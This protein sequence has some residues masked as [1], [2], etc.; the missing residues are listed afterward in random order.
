MR[1]L[2]P[3]GPPVNFY[4]IYMKVPPENNNIIFI[5]TVISLSRTKIITWHMP[6]QRFYYSVDNQM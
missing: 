5:A 3:I 4:F 6:S 2:W 1:A